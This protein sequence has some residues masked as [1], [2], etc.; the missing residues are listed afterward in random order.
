MRNEKL[1]MRKWKRNRNGRHSQC[2][3]TRYPYPDP[4]HILARA[5][6]VGS[7]NETTCTMVPL[8]LLGPESADIAKQQKRLS[9]LSTCCF[10]CKFYVTRPMPLWSNE[11]WRASI[12]SCWCALGRPFTGK[13]TK[14][15]GNHQLCGR[16]MLQAIYVLMSLILVQGVKSVNGNV[17]DCRR[18]LKSEFTLCCE[19]YDSLKAD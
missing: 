11:V 5:R 15:S 13:I 2:P 16:S 9:S 4:I 8:V 3:Q 10:S 14:S 19:S 6:V 7:G 1:E 17:A 12:G 18:Q